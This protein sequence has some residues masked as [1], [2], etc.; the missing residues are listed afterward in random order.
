[1]AD[2]T[3]ISPLFWLPVELLE[4]I[5][6][7]LTRPESVPALTVDKT[8]HNVFA[9]RIWRNINHES[10]IWKATSSAWRAY[11]HL[12]RTFSVTSWY[13]F[14]CIPD[15]P[16]IVGLKIYLKAENSSIFEY[17]MPTLRELTV[18]SILKPF[19]PVPEKSVQN[20][21]TWIKEAE[22]SGQE[23]SVEWDLE[24]DTA[25]K[26]E[27]IEDVLV[28]TVYLERHSI[29]FDFVG[30]CV[31]LQRMAKF[32]SRI[33]EIKMPELFTDNVLPVL[34]GLL[35]LDGV[36][37]SQLRRLNIELPVFDGH[38]ENQFIPQVDASWFPALISLELTFSAATSEFLVHPVF[39]G[40]LA[41]L[42]TLQLGCCDY[43]GWDLVVKWV[44]NVRYLG[45]SF[46]ELML[47]SSVLA[48][49]TPLL[50]EIM[51]EDG[52][53]IMFSATRDSSA[54]LLNLRVLDIGMEE[55]TDY[56]MDSDVFEFIV[57]NAPNLQT[58]KFTLFQSSHFCVY[59]L[60]GE[61]NDSVHH[62]SV[63]FELSAL[64]EVDID[65]LV[66]SFPGLRVLEYG[67]RPFDEKMFNSI[68]QRHSH[69]KVL[70]NR[71]F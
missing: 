6:Q 43:D 68:R 1:M 69:I 67:Q 30:N 63:S 8:L 34:N 48:Q 25:D 3:A 29:K 38:D 26:L 56:D 66:S 55:G 31:D 36:V 21:L 40:T 14:E 9:R 70:R 49:Y 28:E 61:T 58:V 45:F 17:K 33:V 50:E 16:L 65:N 71:A 39:I 27:W 57:L 10:H 15:L 41:S 32:E 12:V 54:Q 11:G 23:V 22:K 2:S 4:E 7:F 59:S 42:T 52:C 20:V 51:I 44:P 19:G 53:E 46:S 24:V 47:E 18:V 5:S 35:K 62:L 37:F 60:E 13:D 64:E